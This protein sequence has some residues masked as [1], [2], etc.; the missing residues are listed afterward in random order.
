[1]HRSCL[2]IA[3]PD[4]SENIEGTKEREFL[5]RIP[6]SIR[7]LSSQITFDLADKGF[8]QLSIIILLK[9][10]GIH[11]DSLVSSLAKLSEI[12]WVY[13]FCG[14]DFDRIQDQ[15]VE[16]VSWKLICLGHHSLV[17]HYDSNIKRLRGPYQIKTDHIHFHLPHG[18][19]LIRSQ[20]SQNYILIVCVKFA[21]LDGF[22]KKAIL[23]GQINTYY[24]ETNM[25][26]SHHHR[27]KEGVFS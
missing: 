27:Q 23:F 16:F 9:D 10:S 22:L 5:V 24:E 2:Y 8:A 6:L 18:F 7:I 3:L 21:I 17:K 25:I 19:D 20:K 4:R 12:Y 15:L 13:F 11:K 14:R 26:K 1:M